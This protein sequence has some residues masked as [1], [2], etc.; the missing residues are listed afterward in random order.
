VFTD[1]CIIAWGATS[2]EILDSFIHISVW[3]TRVFRYS[4]R[5]AKV[6]NL[7]LISRYTLHFL[8][9]CKKKPPCKLVPM[10]GS[11]FCHQEELCIVSS[12]DSKE[13]R[14][15]KKLTVWRFEVEMHKFIPVYPGLRNC[16]A[17][18][19]IPF[20]FVS[21]LQNAESIYQALEYSP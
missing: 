4:T 6:S 8:K 5:E 20:Y 9:S 12:N 11:Y 14:D 13:M 10:S 15:E 18:D 16:L 2:P 17:L 1:W 3:N 19:G 21:K 7:V